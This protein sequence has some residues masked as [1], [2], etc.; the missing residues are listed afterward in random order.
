M[1]DAHVYPLNAELAEL[2]FMAGRPSFRSISRAIG[3][4]HTT[5]A[6]AFAPGAIP[7]WEILHLVVCQLNGDVD[8][9]RK[10]WCDAARKQEN[11]V[12]GVHKIAS[13]STRRIVTIFVLAA[14]A[15]CAGMLLMIARQSTRHR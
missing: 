7:S 3:C 10:L 5:V 4:S 8:T 9:F 14:V 1:P 11:G 15:G 12:S 6:K 2:R 13:V